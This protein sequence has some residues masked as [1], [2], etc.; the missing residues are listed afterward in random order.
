M[1]DS[2]HGHPTMA[3]VPGIAILAPPHASGVLWAKHNLLQ[4]PKFSPRDLPRFG[5]L[6]NPWALLL[7]AGCNSPGLQ[8][9][10]GAMGAKNVE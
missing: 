1:A 3:A 9:G 2:E 6:V 8:I 10:W 5:A 7:N 4:E